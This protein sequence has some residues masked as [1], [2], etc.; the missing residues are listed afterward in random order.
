M[1]KLILPS[2]VFLWSVASLAQIS[3]DKQ[4]HYMAGGIINATVYMYIYN[5]TE[6]RSKAFW[7]SLG[8]STVVGIGKEVRDDI[9]YGNFDNKDLT[10]TILGAL[11]I[12]TTF[13]IITRDKSKRKLR[14]LQSVASK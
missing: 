7:Y 12:S 3:Q 1:K 11:T 5:K 2:C 8:A 6:N 4:M 9:T 13:N 10:A 14:K